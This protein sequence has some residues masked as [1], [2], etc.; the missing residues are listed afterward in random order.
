MKKNFTLFRTFVFFALSVFALLFFVSCEKSSDSCAFEAMNTFMTI[1]SYGK[2]CVKA[3]S[4]VKKRIEQLESRIS[5][6]I[7]T[8]DVYR[9]NHSGGQGI[10]IFEDTYRLTE[11]ALRMAE[12]TEGALNPALF[13]V[14]S[15][16]GF[17]TGN[18]SVPSESEITEL[19]THT[20]FTK[21]KLE[22]KADDGKLLLFTEKEM[23]LDF[24][25]VGKGFAGDEAVRILR[26][27]GIES[28]LLDLGG[29]I[30][31][32]GANP[33]GKDWNVGIKNPWDGNVVC[34]VKINNQAV[35]TS[36]G[37][38]RNFTADDGKTYIHIFDGNTGK[39]VENEIASVTIVCESGMYG[40]A[41]STALFVMG[42]DKAVKFWKNHKDFDFI[43]ITKE[44]KLIYS[45]GLAE[46]ITVLSDFAEECVDLQLS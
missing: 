22:S 44:K 17:T 14:I 23:M 8:S 5:T 36:G 18:Y 46:K 29:N 13:P 41:L 30:Q 35:I 31:V 42:T 24:G 40:D 43:I 28:A 25:S 12:K 26:Q 34:G 16:W 4:V 33:E 1:R 19:L 27:Y 3:N 9:V 20:D 39:P 45:R 15:A 21:V 2:N 10:E 11:F 6:T 38:E 32:I 37:Y 7:E